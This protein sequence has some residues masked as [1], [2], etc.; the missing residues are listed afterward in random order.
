V[1]LDEI[2]SEN[3]HLEIPKFTLETAAGSVPA[4]DPPRD[5]VE[6]SRIA[7]AEKAERTIREMRR[8]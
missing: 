7:K 1:I 3:G 4:L 2:E 8:G 5:A 6:A